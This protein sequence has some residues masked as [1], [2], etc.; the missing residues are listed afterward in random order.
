MHRYVPHIRWRGR[1]TAGKEGRVAGVE[2]GAN[3]DRVHTRNLKQKSINPTLMSHEMAHFEINFVPRLNPRTFQPNFHCAWYVLRKERDRKSS[4]NL[5]LYAFYC[6]WRENRWKINNYRMLQ[7]DSWII[8]LLFIYCL[9]FIYW[10]ICNCM[11]RL[12]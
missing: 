1:Q 8:Y 3:P 11:A 9:L 7:I 6:N 10:F 2:S 4:N 5:L 12:I